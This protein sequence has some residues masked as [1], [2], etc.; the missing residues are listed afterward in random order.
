MLKTDHY[1]VYVDPYGWT[2]VC[3]S[4]GSMFQ[5]S[6]HVELAKHIQNVL[7]VE[8]AEAVSAEP[9][10]PAR[11]ALVIAARKLRDRAK[12]RFQVYG[13]DDTRGGAIWD[14]ADFIDPFGQN[15]VDITIPD[16]EHS[17]RG[18]ES[19]T[20]NHGPYVHTSTPDDP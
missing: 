10:M 9:E 12:L 15:G 2:C 4:Y 13:S 16:Q 7:K 20:V 14:S 8:L 5:T 11:R 6:A 19:F 18:G 17:F 3:G 1:F